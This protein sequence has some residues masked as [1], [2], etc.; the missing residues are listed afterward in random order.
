MNHQQEIRIFKRKL[1]VLEKKKDFIAENRRFKRKII[2]SE[3]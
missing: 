3:N 1:L 2:L